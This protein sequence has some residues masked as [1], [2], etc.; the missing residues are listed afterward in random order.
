[1]ASKYSLL[2]GDTPRES[3]EDTTSLLEKNTVFVRNRWQPTLCTSFLATIVLVLYSLS[4]SWVTKLAVQ[5]PHHHH[6]QAPA[7][8]FPH[9]D[10]KEYIVKMTGQPGD[11]LAHH[12]VYGNPSPKTDDAWFELLKPFNTRVPAERYEA[13]MGNRS[14]VRVADDSGDYYVTLTVYHELHCLMRFRWFLDPEYYANKTWEEQ[15][16]DAALLGHYRHCIWSLLESVMCNGDTSMRT[17]HWDEKKPAP[18]PDSLAERK[19]V[20][21]D[22]LYKWTSDQSFLLQD[23][24]LSHPTYGRLNEKLK[25]I[26]MTE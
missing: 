16:K 8:S 15:S 21:W 4:I 22:W 25:P 5:E 24:L 7:S 6:L 1:M 14:S 23:R 10:E 11:G 12:L 3:D 17:F 18:K 2:S 20:N 13:T 26:K 9:P 19:C